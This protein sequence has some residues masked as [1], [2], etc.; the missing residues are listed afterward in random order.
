MNYKDFKL[1]ILANF[2]KGTLP[3]REYIGVTNAGINDVQAYESISYNH[4]VKSLLI[5]LS[6]SS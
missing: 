2:F 4:Q 3:I 1:Y 5:Q 6:L